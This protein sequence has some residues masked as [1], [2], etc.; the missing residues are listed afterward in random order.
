MYQLSAAV[1][2]EINDSTIVNLGSY[3]STQL[4]H[5]QQH[6]YQQELQH[7]QQQHYHE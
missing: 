2:A 5:Q 7:Q 1:A 4:R 3:S 6:C